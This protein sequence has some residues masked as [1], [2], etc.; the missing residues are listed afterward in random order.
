MNDDRDRSEES[1]G[2]AV[3]PVPALPLAGVGILDLLLTLIGARNG[4]PG[5]RRILSR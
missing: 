1:A 3:T 4:R 5:S 2:T